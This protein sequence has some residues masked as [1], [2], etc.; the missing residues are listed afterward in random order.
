M[1]RED[2]DALSRRLDEIAQ[3]HADCG[4]CFVI[5]ELIDYVRAALIPWKDRPFA[6]SLDAGVPTNGIDDDDIE[7]D[8][9]ASQEMVNPLGIGEPNLPT[10]LKSTF[11]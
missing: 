8:G 7:G 4:D 5:D 1:T 11:I 3:D 9:P 2:Y 6:E 10:Y